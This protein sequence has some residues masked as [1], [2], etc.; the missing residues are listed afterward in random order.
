MMMTSERKFKPIHIHTIRGSSL[1]M[2]ARRQRVD[3][4]HAARWNS[5]DLTGSTSRPRSP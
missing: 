5:A 3:D 4:W 2:F 1:V